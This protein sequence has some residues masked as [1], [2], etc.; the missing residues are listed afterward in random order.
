VRRGRP[1]SRRRERWRGRR[2]LAEQRHDLAVLGEA[3]DRLLRVD[4][5]AVPDDVELGL[6]TR[7]DLCVDVERVGELGRETRGP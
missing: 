6:R 3:A 2:R 1:R 5:L 4:E 7:Y